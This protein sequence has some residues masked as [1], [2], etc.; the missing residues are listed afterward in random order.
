MR[1]RKAIL[2]DNEKEKGIT[3]YPETICLS[4]SVA[5]QAKCLFCPT[6]RGKRISP[7]L[8]P[9]ETLDRILKLSREDDFRGTFI[10]GENGEPLL[11]PQFDRMI[12]SIRELFPHNK[13]VL[14]TNMERMNHENIKTV[15]HN[16]I[17]EIHFNYD[18]ATADTY[19]FMKSLN[20]ETVYQNIK[21]FFQAR[22]E[23]NYSTIVHLQ[24][25]SARRYLEA[26][27]DKRYRQFSDDSKK[28][29]REWYPY[30]RSNDQV[31]QTSILKWATNVSER[32]QKKTPCS[33]LKRIKT[34][35]YIAPSAKT[36]LCCL[37]DNADLV[38]GDLNSQTI[39][40]VWHS[41]ARNDLI[42]ALESQSFKKIGY[43]CSICAD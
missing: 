40:E 33:M 14:F 32:N 12:S 16:K 38:Y 20:F 43:P 29:A 17:D 2:Q 4:T 31:S 30:L 10:I 25:V 41:Q 13:I 5:C 27:G 3:F 8:M 15:L 23:G 11:H 19:Q 26:I 9:Y 1:K 39:K 6:D 7:K 42:E 37:D 24:I 28:A 35:F 34:H 36:Y 21:A 22:E 18:G